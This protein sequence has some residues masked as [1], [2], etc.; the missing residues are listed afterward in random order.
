[1]GCSK[2]LAFSTDTQYIWNTYHRKKKQQ[3]KDHFLAKKVMIIQ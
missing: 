2:L 1:M 3:H